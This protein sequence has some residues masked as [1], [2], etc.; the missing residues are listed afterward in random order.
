MWSPR[1][2]HLRLYGHSESARESA[3][4]EQARERTLI[5]IN[6]AARFLDYITYGYMID[7][8]ILLLTGTLHERD[9]KELLEKCHPLVIL[10]T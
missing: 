7:N 4:R 3:Y 9:T 6:V 8:V 10:P 2:H 5:L 1:L